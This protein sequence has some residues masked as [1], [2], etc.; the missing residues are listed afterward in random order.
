MDIAGSKV[1]VIENVK[2]HLENRQLIMD[3]VLRTK[4]DSFFPHL[5]SQLVNVFIREPH[6]VRGGVRQ[7]ELNNLNP[8]L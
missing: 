2:F 3:A 1:S 4:P 5:V 7:G 8:N 6:F